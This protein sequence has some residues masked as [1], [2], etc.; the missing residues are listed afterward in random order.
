MTDPEFDNMLLQRLGQRSDAFT[1]AQRDLTDQR[2]KDYKTL[3]ESV[4]GGLLTIFPDVVSIIVDEVED[5][6]GF[7]VPQ[8]W[9]L[10]VDLDGPEYDPREEL[11]NYRWFCPVR[12]VD[13]LEDFFIPE[14]VDQVRVIC[15]AV[16]AFSSTV[17]KNMNLHQF[18]Y[19]ADV[20]LLIDRSGV[21]S[22]VSFD[23][24]F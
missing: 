11:L 13:P 2:G 24:Y 8:D 4:G 9:Y 1:E 21:T 12:T 18:V 19:G 6:Y 10:K 22:L 17:Q 20:C 3:L 14:R 15:D 7:E 16:R 23:R 5:I